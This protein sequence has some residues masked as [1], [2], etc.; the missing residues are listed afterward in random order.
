[1]NDSQTAT[2]HVRLARI[3][4]TDWYDVDQPTTRT[5]NVLENDHFSGD[6]R[7]L[8]VITSVSAPTGNGFVSVTSDGRSLVYQPGSDRET[9][10]YT[11]DEQF[12]ESVQ[13]YPVNRLHSDHA[14]A[15][16]NGPGVVVDPIANDF[17]AH[18]YIIRRHGSYQGN[19]ILTDV[20]SS[21]HGAVVTITDD[22]QV[23]YVPGRDFV[24]RDS[25]TY[26]VDDFLNQQVFVEVIRRVNDDVVHVTG[27][28]VRNVE[29]PRQ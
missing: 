9:F 28:R 23:R 3:T 25:F 22:G 14:V 4:E 2:V 19:R 20:S 11:V 27:P 18:D 10:T 15:D 29:R 1:M 17:P 16:Q 12:T 7:G 5:L 24:G 6:Y 21:V 8:G 13:I 26:T